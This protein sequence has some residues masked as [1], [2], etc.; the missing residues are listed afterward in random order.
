LNP[1][2][3]GYTMLPMNQGAILTTFDAQRYTNAYENNAD[4]YAI[5]SFLA[6]K[7]ASIP[8][9]VYSTNSGQKARISL[10]RY[11]SLTRGLGNPGAFDQA[12]VHR[13]AAYDENEILENTPLS[14]ILTRPNSYQ[15]Q[16]Q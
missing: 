5:V 8:W 11:K 9:Y 6:R 7:A 15:G 1:V 12:I 2:N 4:V 3:A 10:E 16:D 14:N 13:K